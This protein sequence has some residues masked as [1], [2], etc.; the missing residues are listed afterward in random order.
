MSEDIEKLIEIYKANFPTE[1]TNEQIVEHIQNDQD[2]LE[3]LQS[4]T[5]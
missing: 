5:E 3:M 4:M 1:E 2:L